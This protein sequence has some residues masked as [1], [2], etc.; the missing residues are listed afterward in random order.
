MQA[1][2]YCIRCCIIVL[3]P[4]VEYLPPICTKGFNMHISDGFNSL[5]VMTCLN[6]KD[7]PAMG[8]VQKVT[9]QRDQSSIHLASERKTYTYFIFSFHQ[10]QGFPF[11]R[12]GW[13]SSQDR[14]KHKTVYNYTVGNGPPLMGVM[15][16][17][18]NTWSFPDY[19]LE[20]PGCESLLI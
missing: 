14:K 3:S 11:G 9:Y 7:S 16:E 18:T 6:L 8:S 13:S 2:V 19:F 10:R 4:L 17:M 20:W 15:D 5:S 1:A 12:F